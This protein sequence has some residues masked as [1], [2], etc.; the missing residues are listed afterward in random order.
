MRRMTRLFFV[1]SRHP[2]GLLGTAITTASGVLFLVLLGIELLGHEGDPY[3]GMITFLVL[4][5]VFVFG[6]SLIPIGVWLYRRKVRRTGIE[7]DR[8][9]IIDLNNGATRRTVL[10][11]VTLTALNL[12]I[13]S[14]AVIKGIEYMDTTSFCGETCHTVMSP[15]YTTYQS[16]PHS[17]VKCAECHIGPGADWFVKSKLSGAWQLVSVTFD[18]YQRPI[19][20][21]VHNLRPARDTC[22]QCH[23]PDKFVGDKLRIISRYQEDEDNTKLLTILLMRVGGL[24]GRESEGIHWHVDPANEVRYRSDETR[25]TMYEIELRTDDGAVKTWLPAEEPG[26]DDHGEW[27]TMDCIDCHNRP[28]HIYRM[29]GPEVDDSLAAGRIASDLPFVKREGMRLIQAD[30]ESHEAAR[31]AITDGLRAFYASDYPDVA[32]ARDAD[33][34]AAAEELVTIYTRNVHPVMNIQW[35]AYPNHI[36]HERFPGC[37]RCHDYTH[38]TADGDEITQDCETCHTILAYEEEDPEILAELRP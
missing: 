36:G 35:G 28:S 29:P 26:E 21:P 20:T 6:L 18:L 13:V 2:L 31:V 34:D 14:L 27:R 22:E 17:R 1:L 30:F 37:F 24:Q 8:L 9:P 15:E 10:I 11:F 7:E 32:S 33:I 16:S 38:A 3:L 23:W 19:P 4:P 25:A 5:G 12:A